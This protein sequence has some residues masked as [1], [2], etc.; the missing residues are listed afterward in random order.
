M[1]AHIDEM[2]TK[3]TQ[4]A[5]RLLGEQGIMPDFIICRS[6]YSLDSIRRKKIEEFAHLPSDR[7]IAAPDISSVYHM[8][9]E[10]EAQDMGTKL[11]THLKLD[12]SH[13]PDWSLWQQRVDHIEHPERKVNVAVIGK[14]VD[15]GAFSMTDS[16]LSICHALQ[17][18]GAEIN[19]GVDITWIDAKLLENNQQK[20]QELSGFDGV[21]VPGGF[22]HSGVEGKINAIE[23]VRHK[24]IP[25][26]GLCYGLQLA[27]VEYARHVCKLAKAHTTEVDPLTPHPVIDI[28]PLQKAI[29]QSNRYGG[30]MRLGAYEAHLKPGTLVHKLYQKAD[31]D[32]SVVHERHR[33]R[34]E[35]NPAYVPILEDNGFIFSGHHVRPDDT[36]L[37][38]FA[39][40]ANHPFFVATQAH[41]EF[42]SR[43]GNPNPLFLG[44]VKACAQQG[45]IAPFALS[46][47]KG[48]ERVI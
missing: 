38:E 29:L 14:Y 45:S 26:L 23:Y 44:F 40:L 8:P 48:Q 6:Q 18:A 17:H 39:E 24:N 31:Q 43:L 41:P 16:Y 32:I 20:C 34:Y 7:I 10:L 30:T 28:L 15:S 19:V 1:P 21:I 42:K 25:F 3:P 5:I 12:A 46:M 2:K 9:I 36:I 13:K 33:H 4:Q 47:S 37:M 35:V 22:G 11:L 27:A